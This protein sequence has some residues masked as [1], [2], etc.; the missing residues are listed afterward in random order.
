MD[1][2]SWVDSLVRLGGEAARSSQKAQLSLSSEVGGLDVEDAELSERVPFSE[3]D[4]LLTGLV[5]VSDWE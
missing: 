3:S 4:W 2:S 1:L 5:S